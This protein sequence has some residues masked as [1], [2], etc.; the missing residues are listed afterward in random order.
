VSHGDPR[1]SKGRPGTRAPHCWLERDGQRI[2]TVDL[3]G[4]RFVVL[5]APRSD[6]WCEAARQAADSQHIPVEVHRLGGDGLTDAGDETATA[7]GLSPDGAVIV[8]PDGFVGWRAQSAPGDLQSYANEIE[9]AF[10]TLVCR[11][12]SPA[13]GQ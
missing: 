9:R 11:R 2:S 4:R 7:Y 5:G 13:A 12:R 1:H 8:R 3:F 10:E 6:R